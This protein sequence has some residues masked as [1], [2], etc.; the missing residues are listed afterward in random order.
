MFLPTTT[1]NCHCTIFS[2]FLAL[3]H[4]QKTF[5][6][7]WWIMDSNKSLTCLRKISPLSPSET[8]S[9][10]TCRGKTR[11]IYIFKNVYIFSWNRLQFFFLSFLVSLV[12]I[13]K[14][15]SV[16]NWE[17]L[18]S[19]TW[20]NSHK[21]RILI[22]TKDICCQLFQNKVVEIQVYKEIK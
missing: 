22:H 3:W 7:C 9:I 10:F 17:V 19:I 11:Y 4:A 12:V 13:N 6:C 5:A 21:V 18:F 2:Y 1:N 15:N 16:E 14:E 8:I 20:Y